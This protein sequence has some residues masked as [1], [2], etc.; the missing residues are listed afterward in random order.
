M[1]PPIIPAWFLIHPIRDLV[2]II[3]PHWRGEE[4]LL[5]SLR[6][7]QEYTTIPHEIILVDNAC[8][9]GSIAAARRGFSQVRIVSAGKN[10]GFAGG[11]NLGMSAA[12][13]AYLV[14][15]NNDAIATPLWLE[16]LVETM[17]TDARIAACQ[18]KIRAIDRQ[19]YFDYAGACGGYLDFLGYPFCRGRI[20]DT[21]EKDEHQYD[22]TVEI[23][24][25]SGACCLLRRSAVE[26]VGGLD[27]SFFAHMEEIDL[28]W[29]L[30]LAGYLVVAVPASTVYH[31]AG[32][33][34]Q[35]GAP[36]KAY[37]NHRN[38]LLMLLKNHSAAALALAFPLRLFLDALEFLR[39]LLA[40]RRG[41]HAFMILRAVFAVALKM[42]RVL[43]QRRQARRVR[44]ISAPAMRAKF[45]P[46]SIVWN[47]FIRGKRRFSD[48]PKR[49]WARGHGPSKRKNF[50]PT[51]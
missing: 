31:Q 13:G 10:L 12:A 30:H 28:N 43:K 16:P 50:P 8:D 15:F 48:L 36:A 7:L 11:C 49:P 2:S 24:W 40:H 5:R 21:I 19:D 46:R 37:L 39:Q 32:S 20:F 35:A 17:K 34:L 3:I 27:A 6:S 25:A 38:S 9:D 23:F 29:R 41:R 14:L 22:D 44:K 26:E 33:T 47:Y 42:P 51:F 18:P 4:I 1:R 45:H